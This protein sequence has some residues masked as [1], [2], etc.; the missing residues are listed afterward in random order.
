MVN[1]ALSVAFAMNVT[2]SFGGEGSG[3]WA[4][5][6]NILARTDNGDANGL[7]VDDEGDRLDL[8]SVL[9]GGFS[10]ECCVLMW[11]M[12]KIEGVRLC[13]ELLVEEPRAQGQISSAV[14]V[15]AVPSQSI[16]VG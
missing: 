11:K 1:N 16:K 4:S 13:G 3:K 8:A 14:K 7:L 5:N 10:R 2:D 6:H 9:E 15:G 12:L